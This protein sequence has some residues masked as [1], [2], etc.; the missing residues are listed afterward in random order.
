MKK[1]L[2]T[3]TIPFLPN[4]S[5]STAQVL[6]EMLGISFQGRSLGIAFDIWKRMLQ[7]EV[8][9]WFGLSGAMVPAGMRSLIV[10]LI[11]NRMIDVLVST[12]ANLFH[13][14]HETLGRHHFIGTP[15]INDTE[16]RREMVDRMYDTYA[17]EEEFRLLD[18]C[19][20]DWAMNTLDPKRAYSTRE[21]FSLWGK[22]LATKQ[23]T[24]GIVTAAYKHGVPVYCPSFADS[25]YGIALAGAVHRLKKTVQIDVVSDTLE[26]AQLFGRSKQSGVIY[27]GGGV[28]KNFT[29]QS[30]V[31]ADILFDDAPDGHKYAIQITADAPHWGGLSG[32]TFSEAESWGKI[33]QQARTVAV[34][35]DATL[36]L[37]FLTVGLAQEGMEFARKRKKPQF[38]FDPEVK[39]EYK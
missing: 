29:N 14:A 22:H 7:D 30:A 34:Y 19:F 1:H 8:V 39:V 27:I 18:E 10:F 2:Q 13:D 32:C 3:P 11:E 16:L 35:A 17:D 38:V 36:C 23:K 24:E 37:P 9:I 5:K 20:G 6:N 31:T 26:T 15:N 28:P 21:M 4:S 12:G 25:S 33:N